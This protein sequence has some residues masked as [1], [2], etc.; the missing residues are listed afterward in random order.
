[1]KQDCIKEITTSAGE[2]FVGNTF[3]LQTIAFVF[4]WRCAQH[5]DLFGNEV[6]AIV[7]CQH[8]WTYGMEKIK[9]KD[10]YTTFYKFLF[11]LLRD[12]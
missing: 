8:P 1:M 3:Y 6:M 9:E 12:I 4:Y 5:L 10:L 11:L 7:R 2:Q